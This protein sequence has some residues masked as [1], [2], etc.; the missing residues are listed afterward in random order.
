MSNYN[1]LQLNAKDLSELKA[2]AADLGLKV[3]NSVTKDKLVYEILDQQAVVGAQRKTSTA[4]ETPRKKR[5][6]VA[7]KQPTANTETAEEIPVIEEIKTEEPAKEEK[8]KKKK[9]QAESAKTNE[10]KVQKSKTANSAKKALEK[11]EE[12]KTEESEETAPQSKAEKVQE[13]STA[14]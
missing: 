5:V 8:S 2:I 14:E 9:T 7:V 3:S 4:K 11:P 12:P 13:T 1:I 10:P 6:R